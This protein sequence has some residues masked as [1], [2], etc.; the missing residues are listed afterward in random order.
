LATNVREILR[1]VEPQTQM[2]MKNQLIYN[3]QCSEQN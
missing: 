1:P 2:S 3:A